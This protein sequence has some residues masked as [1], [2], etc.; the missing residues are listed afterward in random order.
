[1]KQNNVMKITL[2]TKNLNLVN[3]PKAFMCHQIVNLNRF[4]ERLKKLAPKQKNVMI[5]ITLLNRFTNATSALVK[6]LKTKLNLNVGKE[7]I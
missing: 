4:C 2:F 3:V 5:K 6:E 1:V 7:D